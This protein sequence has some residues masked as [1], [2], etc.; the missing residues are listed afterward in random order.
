VDELIDQQDNQTQNPQP[1]PTPAA[2]PKA[3]AKPAEDIQLKKA[4]EILQ[5]KAQAA[6]VG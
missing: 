2:K 5:D 6:K 4:I 3:D 1:T